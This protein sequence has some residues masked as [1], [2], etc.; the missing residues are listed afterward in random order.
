MTDEKQP[1]LPNVIRDPG[2]YRE[3]SKPFETF[4]AANEAINAFFKDVRELRKK[5]KLPDVYI[6]L[7]GTAYR[8]DAADDE[9]SEGDWI[10]SQHHGSSLNCEAMCAW[11]YGQEAAKR[12]E[13]ISKQM[14]RGISRREHQ[15]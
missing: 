9:E 7:K 13:A 5:H 12:Q 2:G 8:E 3:L 14:S 11:A 4:T 15:K 6:I 10:I 1:D